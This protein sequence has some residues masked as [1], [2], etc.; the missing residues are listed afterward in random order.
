MAEIPPDVLA[1][2]MCEVRDRDNLDI[3]DDEIAYG[4]HRITGYAWLAQEAYAAGAGDLEQQR[5]LNAEL[6]AQ[7][8]R[9]NDLPELR[10]NP[11]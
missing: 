2:L 9:Y 10:R 4:H 5:A 11:Q 7:I 1:D 3:S 6:R 8:R